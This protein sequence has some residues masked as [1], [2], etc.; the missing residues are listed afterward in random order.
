M[1]LVMLTWL[2]AMWWIR[3]GI[4]T[5]PDEPWAPPD[6]PPTPPPPPPLLAGEGLSERGDGVPLTLE[7]NERQWVP[8]TREWG[9][10]S[11]CHHIACCWGQLQH[12]WE[13][14]NQNKELKDTKTLSWTEGSTRAGDSCDLWSTTEGTH[15]SYPL[16][17]KSINH[18]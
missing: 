10:Q 13:T 8:A 17:V 15:Y 7:N 18:N 6:P 4:A 11:F 16:I 2:A 14:L 12:W 3:C 5:L 9:D 1:L